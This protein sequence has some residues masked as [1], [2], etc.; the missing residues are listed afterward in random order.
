MWNAHGMALRGLLLLLNVACVGL[1][2]G[3]SEDIEVV[4]I[5]LKVLYCKV[6]FALRGIIRKNC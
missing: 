5:F 4:I 6:S 2:F 1:F 3:L